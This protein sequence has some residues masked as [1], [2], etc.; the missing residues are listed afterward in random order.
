[1]HNTWYWISQIGMVAFGASAVV[2]VARKKRIGFVIGLAGQP[3]FIIASLL[4]RQWGLLVMSLIF[5]GSWTYGIY[6]SFWKKEKS[7]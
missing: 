2:L 7:S 3:F 4:S 5:T 1:M 6:E